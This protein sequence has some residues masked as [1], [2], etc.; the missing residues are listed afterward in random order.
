MTGLELQARLLWRRNA[1]LAGL[2]VLLALLLVVYAFLHPGLLS[3]SGVARFTQNWFPIALVAVAQTLVML[4]GGIDLAMGAMVSLGCVLAATLVG[5]TALGAA[6]GIAAVV[7][8][9]AV[10]GAATGTIVAL[11]RLPA[12]IVTLAGSFLIGGAALLVMPRPGGSIPDWLSN[13]LVGD[14][15]TAPVLLVLLLLLWRLLQA[16]PSGHAIAAAGDNPQGAYRSG[17]DVPLA[18][19]AAYAISGA[20]AAFA[21][22]YVAAQT[23]AGDPVIGTPLTLDSITAAVLGGVGFLGGQGTLRGALAGSLLLAVLINVMFF[24]GLPPVA[25]YVAKGLIIVAAMALRRLRERP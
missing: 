1:G 22:F 11:L 12:I 15:P 19:I 6:L 10:V 7:G 8:A 3:L 16:T 14:L 18:R 13:A 25:Q 2:Y 21:G 4:M 23:G 20:L 24:I 9:G 17:I 5:G